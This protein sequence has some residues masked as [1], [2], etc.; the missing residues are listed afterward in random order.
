MCLEI[1]CCH[2]LCGEAH[3]S[4]SRWFSPDHEGITM[5]RISFFS[6]F[7]AALLGISFRK[8]TFLGHLYP[9]RF[10]QQWLRRSSSVT[11]APGLGIT[12]AV[13]FSPQRSSERPSTAALKTPKGWGGLFEARLAKGPP[14]RP[15]EGHGV[16][17]SRR[18]GAGNGP[19]GFLSP[20]PQLGARSVQCLKTKSPSRRKDL[21]GNRP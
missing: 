14:L 19:P 8:K 16:R 21:A 12:T 5:F 17:G 13:T 15:W 1:N 6:I 3:T 10:M 20:P 2:C 18:N 4:H 7:P 11:T 9:A